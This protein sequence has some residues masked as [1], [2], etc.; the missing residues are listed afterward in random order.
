MQSRFHD[1]AGTFVASLFVILGIALALETRGMTAM[2]SVFPTTISIA[3]IVFS[4]VLILR[5]LVLTLRGRGGS[6]AQSDEAPATGG[7]NARRA[8]FVGAMIAWIALIPVIGFLLASI[9]GYFAVMVV[10]MHERMSLKQIALLIV[11]GVAILAGF[12]LLMTEVLLI[13]M[14]RGHLF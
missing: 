5:N 12:Y 7:S 8:F 2:G 6:E 9:A 1:P 10:A 13:P 11:L 14:P 4:A 3:L